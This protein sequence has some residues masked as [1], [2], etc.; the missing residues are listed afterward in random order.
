MPI[1]LLTLV[2]IAAIPPTLD[3]RRDR[4]KKYLNIAKWLTEQVQK[5]KKEA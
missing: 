3:Y 4:K 2:V 1:F 5:D